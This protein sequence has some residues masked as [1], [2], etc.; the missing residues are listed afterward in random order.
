MIEVIEP[1][2]LLALGILLIGLEVI[3]LSFIL[4]FIGV[5]FIIVS[6]V[7]SIYVFDNGLVQIAAALVIAIVLAYALRD[8][9]LKK[10]SKS[11]D[12]KEERAHVSGIGYVEN[13]IVKFDGTYWRTTN[14]LSIYKN[15][16]QVEIIDV[17]NNMVVLKKE[18]HV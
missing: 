10:I 8:Y 18:Y 11:S 2:Y 7:S 4:F 6:M 3:T 15:G 14:D 9:L 1:S 5:G 12:E 17:V 16:D 13:G